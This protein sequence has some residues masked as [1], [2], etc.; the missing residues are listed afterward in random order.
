MLDQLLIITRH[1]QR[2]FL[3]CVS[4]TCM[5]TFHLIHST[6][7]V[8]VW[9][10]FRR[11]NLPTLIQL[12]FFSFSGQ[13]A[14]FYL[15]FLFPSEL[16]AKGGNTNLASWTSN[17]VSKNTTTQSKPVVAGKKQNNC[18][19]VS[20]THVRQLLNRHFLCNIR[21]ALLLLTINRLIHPVIISFFF[22]FCLMNK[23]VSLI[24]SLFSSSSFT[25]SSL[26]A[27]SKKSKENLAKK[28]QKNSLHH[29]G[30]LCMHCEHNSTDSSEINLN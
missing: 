29:P 9:R 28:A 2:S 3:V 22:F 6:L 19:K 25:W 23:M 7:S 11:S 4:F 16:R 26:F 30:C 24:S 12:S 8:C 1:W 13:Y 18:Q 15:K 20:G 5:F 27:Q 17:T 21:A 14:F 10:R